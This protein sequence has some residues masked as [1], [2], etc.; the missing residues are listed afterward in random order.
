MRQELE[1]HQRPN[2][3]YESVAPVPRSYQF[4]IGEWDE[5]RVA[6]SNPLLFDVSHWG[7]TITGENLQ[8]QGCHPAVIA[9][10]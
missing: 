1:I 9:R 6:T 8:R 4:G 5:S 10:G 3:K 2:S 7:D